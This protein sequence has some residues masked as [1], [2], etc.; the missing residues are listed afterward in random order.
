MANE[1]KDKRI[2]VMVAN[3]GVE[4]IELAVPMRAVQKAGARVDVVAPRTG[5]VQMMNNLDKADVIDVDHSTVEVEEYD[6]DALILPGGV[7]NPD[8]LRMD[9]NAVIFTKAMWN[10]GKPIAAICHG[11]W[12]LVEAGITR[13]RTLTSW[14]SL[15]TDIRNSGG[16]WVDEEVHADAGLVT[17]RTPEDLPAFCNKM[18]QEFQKPRNGSHTSIQPRQRLSR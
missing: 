15:L 6:Y 7:A 9:R 5:K 13:G 18:I 8:R 11:P 12:T 1:L 14:P 4:E 2:A 10:A 17:S 3:E 16:T